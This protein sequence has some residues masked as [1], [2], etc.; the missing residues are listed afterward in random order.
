MP[1]V[2]VG[3]KDAS[4]PSLAGGFLWVDEINHVF[5]A[6]GGF[7]PD[8]RPTDFNTWSYDTKLDSWS[9][10]PTQ[11]ENP[12]Y[13]AYGMGATAADAGVGYYLGGYH[14]NQTQNSWYDRR[15][16]SSTLVKFD[17]V[18]RRYSNTSGPD[19]RG[20]GDRIMV[21]IPASTSGLLIFLGGVAQDPLTR[22]IS[23]V[24]FILFNYAD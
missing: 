4:V 3:V 7:F 16:Y 8:S 5:Y 9:I 22:N 19:S 10:V 15:L 6:F 21:F 2:N 17:M 11:G 13:V 14:D 18:N 1:N 24:S 20:R 23:G 12:T